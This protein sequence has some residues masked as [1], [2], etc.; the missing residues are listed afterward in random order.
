MTARI[1]ELDPFPLSSPIFFLNSGSFLT[2][3]HVNHTLAGIYK[4]HTVNANERST[5]SIGSVSSTVKG[6]NPV[7]IDTMDMRGS[8]QN[9]VYTIKPNNG[10]DTDR[11]RIL[12]VSNLNRVLDNY[13]QVV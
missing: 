5:S 1:Q 13:C 11:L 10:G 7:P 8:V 12:P 6:I 4:D 3:S 9:I 2:S